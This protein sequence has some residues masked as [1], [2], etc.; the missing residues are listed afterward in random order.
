MSKKIPYVKIQIFAINT[1]RSIIEK[2]STDSAGV[3]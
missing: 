1:L 3:E 2:N